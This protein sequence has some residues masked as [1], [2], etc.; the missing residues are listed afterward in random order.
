MKINKYFYAGWRLQEPV[1]W[2]PARMNW[3]RSLPILCLEHRFLRTRSMRKPRLMVHTV[4]CTL[5]DGAQAGV[6]R[7]VDKQLFNCLPI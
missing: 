1:C 6:H 4:F 7:I 2:L 5:P 3:K